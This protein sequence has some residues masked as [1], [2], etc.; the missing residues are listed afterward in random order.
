MFH[1]G[2]DAII[3]TRAYGQDVRVVA[4]HGAA[5]L[6][7]LH[8]AEVA[9]VG[10]HFPGHGRADADSHLAVPHVDADMTTLL[11]EAGPFRACMKQGLRHIMTAHV[12]YTQVDARVATLSG[13][14]LG[15]VLRQRFGFD[16]SIWSD[17]LCMKGVGGSVYNAASQAI[18]AGCDVLLVCDPAGVRE[19]YESMG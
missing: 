16:G 9:A 5:C 18:G 14:W 19:L 13:F 11:R 4:E 17:D 8:A 15:E 3:G 10:K 12:V 7:G 2:G 6:K 1:A